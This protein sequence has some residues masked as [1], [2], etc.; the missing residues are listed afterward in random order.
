V[1]AGRRGAR[2]IIKPRAA[3][4]RA[5]GAATL[6]AGLS[7]VAC[8][9]VATQTA[10][11]SAGNP[12]TIHGV[13]RM[14]QTRTPD[15][16]VGMLGTQAINTDLSM[17]WAGYLFNW[18]DANQF[19]PEL[20]TQVPTLRNG[21]ISRD[22]LAITY[23]LRRGVMWQDGAPFTAD[24]VIFS[25]HAVMNPKNIV[26]SRDPYDKI[27]RIEKLGP[28]AIVVHLK[29]RL[30]PFVATFFTMSSHTY[31]VL[32][33]H[34]LG[35]L[36]DINRA[37][38]DDLPVGTGPF[39]IASNEKGSLIRFVANPS[40]WR[41]PPKL[42]EID[43]RIIPNDNTVLTLLKT[44]EID[45]Y[46][47]ASESQ[48]PSLRGIPGTR[49]IVSPFTRFAD[50]GFNA[51][52]PQLRDKRVRQALAYGTDRRGLIDKVTHGVNMPADSDQPPFFWAH[53]AGL[54]QYAYDPARAAA[55]LDA[56]GWRMGHDGLRRK[57][58]EALQLVM[59]G[60]TGSTT[61]S[62]TE[63]V[64]QQEWQQLGIGVTI[65]N[66]P[67][68]LL[69][70][71][72]GDGGIEQTGK[73]DVAFEEWANGVDP[74]ESLLFLCSMQPPQGWNIYH[75]CNRE[76]DAAEAAAVGEYD[77]E[78]RKAAYAKIQRI[79]ADELPILVVWFVRRVDVVNTDLKNY[80]PA[81]AVTPFWNTWEWRI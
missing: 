43:F 62:E 37:A 2:T 32:P 11:T 6:A 40:Y 57:G 55:L 36:T 75:F 72:L 42:K 45:F 12:W 58:G 71:P 31:A 20:A 80:R 67:S 64:I 63:Q 33:V 70:A 53:A 65:K 60:F 54:P 38:Y 74:D 47:R 13:L 25:W 69:Y 3:W 79:L 46:L 52:S 21:G 8:T 26:V 61:V 30:A 4:R 10:Q 34:L 56:A 14:A 18:S 49:L 23:H 9:P 77:P 5:V 76:L 39:R 41:G 51:G 44:H 1:R 29:Q 66:Y 19:V 73:F 50:L 16:L 68:S 48:V 15:N 59:V 28:Y 81:H 24:D 35:S 17:F 22:G 27:E 78:R 7:C